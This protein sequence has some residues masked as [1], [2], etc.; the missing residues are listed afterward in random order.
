MYS[1]SEFRKGLNIELDGEPYVIVDFQHVKPGKGGAF[2]RTKIKN[3]L[4][5][6]VLEKT[7]RS[8]EKFEKPDVAE[9][10][11]QFLYESEGNCYFMDTESYE[12]IF[13]TKEQLGDKIDYLKENF[14][15]D[16]L[17]FNGAPLGIE[18]PNFVELSVAE[19]EPD[20]RGDT[21][22]GGGKPAK[23]ETGAYI[24]VP[25]FVN[26]GDKIKI[27]TRSGTYIERVK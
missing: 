24:T 13:F 5:G 21:A 2:V 11:M 3:L 6:R 22:S 23:L 25:F 18:L 12:Q 16:V 4:D 1:T 8:G 27:D 20:V 7:F 15:V 19:T 9:K 14:V 10:N 26:I 17:F